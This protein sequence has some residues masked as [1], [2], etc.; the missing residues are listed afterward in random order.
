[1]DW[2]GAVGAGT[3]IALV[4][5][6]VTAIGWYVA[7]R[8]QRKIFV[9][10]ARNTARG[11]LVSALREEQGTLSAIVA[12]VLRLDIDQQHGF[13]KEWPEERWRALFPEYRQIRSR[14]DAVR[15][16]FLL[17]QYE[18]LFP[19]TADCRRQLVDYFRHSTDLFG[20][21]LA[22]ANP[23]RRLAAVERCAQV[24]DELEDQRCLI[25]DFLVHIQNATLGQ[26]VGRRVAYREPPDQRVPRVVMRRNGTLMIT[27][28]FGNRWQGTRKRDSGAL[29]ST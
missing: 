1:M 5:W 12:L 13:A 7:L 16:I 2:F 21:F 8:N 19:E 23:Q 25:E 14:S 27:D 29:T 28:G 18:V 11:E 3:A 20:F 9:F 26:V 4:G 15:W 22:L 17:E 6:L 10:Q 24:R